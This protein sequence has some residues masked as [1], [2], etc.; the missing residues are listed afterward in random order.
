[1]SGW[2]LRVNSRQFPIELD[3]G[4]TFRDVLA[5][6]A[7]CQSQT[8]PPPPPRGESINWH[9]ALIS[10]R[11]RGRKIQFVVARHFNRRNRTEQLQ[12]P[13]P[14][15]RRRR[16]GIRK[17]GES[18][19]GLE[20]PP[21]WGNEDFGERNGRIFGTFLFL[22][23]N[24][25]CKNCLLCLFVPYNCHSG[26]GRGMRTFSRKVDEILSLRLEMRGER[27]SFKKLLSRNNRQGYFDHTR[28]GK[29]RELKTK[30]H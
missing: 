3:P 10:S 22:F 4:R 29:A 21:N 1:M 26:W 2:R 24:F 25:L 8:Q 9:L 20:K 30:S 27:R 16:K 23:V 11:G 28:I 12:S 6:L 18:Q 15:S 13:R 17:D 19:V 5:V 7:L 14:S